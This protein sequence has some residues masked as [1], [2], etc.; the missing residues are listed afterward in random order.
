METKTPRAETLKFQG[1]A[2]RVVRTLLR[3]P[4]ISRGIGSR[5]VTLYV[6][7]RKSGTRY[8]VPVAYMRDGDRLLIGSPFGW[9]RNLRTGEP[10][11]I[12]LRGKLRSADVEVIKDEAGVVADLA[13]MSSDNKQFAKFN[14]IGFD[15]AGQPNADDLHAAWATGAHVV[16][17]TPR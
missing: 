14:K 9:V 6:V 12:R 15:E 2:N 7:G 3:T 8:V 13:R 11:Q 1:A 5:L 16:R 17:L 4:L 10:I